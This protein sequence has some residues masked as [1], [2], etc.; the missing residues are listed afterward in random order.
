MV[1][2]MARNVFRISIYFNGE[3]HEKKTREAIHLIMFQYIGADIILLV[4]CIW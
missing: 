1:I 3:Q 2:F 4:V